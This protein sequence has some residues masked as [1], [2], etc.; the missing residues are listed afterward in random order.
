MRTMWRTRTG[1]FLVLLSFFLPLGPTCS[2]GPFTGLDLVRHGEPTVAVV[3]WSIAM[4]LALAGLIA[5]WAPMRKTTSRVILAI[6]GV[7]V[8][9]FLLW[10]AAFIALANYGAY[11]YGVSF[12]KVM[13]EYFDPF[14]DHPQY[15]VGLLGS[16][17]GYL[18][19][20]TGWVGHLPAP[21]P[22][23]SSDQE[24]EEVV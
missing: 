1:L 15:Y 3:L 13:T 2:S 18:L 14:A 16:I 23:P 10:V 5:A 12:T 6:Q 20:F 9:S 22:D 7:T 19:A 4:V 11:K 8:A 24:E 21:P 17:L